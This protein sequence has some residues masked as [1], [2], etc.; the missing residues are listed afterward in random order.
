MLALPAV[1]GLLWPG[2]FSTHD[3][4]HPVWV[5]EMY[6]A[7]ASGQLPPRWAANVSFE[8]GY[9]LFHFVYPLPY[10]LGALFY[11]MGAS[12]VLS[13][14]LVTILAVLASFVFMYLWMRELI[15]PG[16]ALIAALVYIYTPYRALDIYVRGALGETVGF[17]FLALLGYGVTRT[18]KRAD[19]GG[20]I[21]TAL[22]AAGLVLS[23]NLMAYAGFLILGLYAL[24]LA[25]VF[26]KGLFKVFLGVVWGLLISGYFWLPAL[27]DKHLMV[28]STVFNFI[29]HF[30][31]IKQLII[32]SWGH[33]ASLWGPYDGLSFQ[34]GVINLIAVLVAGI[35]LLIKVIEKKWDWLLFFWL[36]VFGGA[37]LMMNVRSMLV[38]EALPLATYF[39]F[40]WRMLM[41][42]TIASS[43][44]AGLV[45][46]KFSLGGWKMGVMIVA[47]MLT[48]IYYFIDLDSPREI[49]N[50]D[51]FYEFL[52]RDPIKGGDIS[53]KYLNNTEEYLRLP[54][55]VE[56]RPA[57]LPEN[58]IEASEGLKI[59]RAQKINA[60]SW[61]IG[62]SGSGL[63]TAH[64]YN[65]PGWQA[66]INEQEVELQTG[67]PWG[68][69]EVE[70][71][72]GENEIELF[73]AQPKSARA[74]NLV[75]GLAFLGL[76]A[77]CQPNKKQKGGSK[78]N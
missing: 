70:V 46:D 26:G 57:A 68:Q 8:Y 50:E 41:V 62:T 32:P 9:P 65:L 15:K 16:A 72:N 5:F 58:K 73:Y 35:L 25:V 2:Y 55:S 56:E 29:D 23:H 21:A 60:V 71:R 27:T 20:V 14:E 38:W 74:V 51:A 4:M 63:L 75:S 34:I 49:S 45:V 31:F 64:I 33:G 37:A 52:A 54:K 61:K 7:I 11:A 3:A 44:V 28:D 40:P 66:R 53:E 1:A 19:K 48:N 12:L 77:Y 24:V 22:G 6:E 42:T 36:A 18:M 10:Y 76:L 39:Q 59:E 69:I 78:S 17:A 13:V 43:V 30:P 47:I 67:K